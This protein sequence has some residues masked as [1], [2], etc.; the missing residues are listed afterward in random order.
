MAWI[1]DVAH[2]LSI[3][4]HESVTPVRFL[5]QDCRTEYSEPNCDIDPWFGRRSSCLVHDFLGDDPPRRVIRH[6]FRNVVLVLLVCG[7]DLE[8]CC[9]TGCKRYDVWE[10]FAVVVVVLVL[11]DPVFQSVLAD[12]FPAHA[13]IPSGM[14][15]FAA[16]NAA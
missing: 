8:D 14:V 3:A 4:H 12:N 7:V 6:Q 15:I 9:S 5:K 1:A 11:R 13:P 2:S 10:L 16:R